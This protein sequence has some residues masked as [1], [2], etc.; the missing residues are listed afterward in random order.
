LL[1]GTLAGA[2]RAA[3]SPWYMGVGAGVSRTDI[4]A[5]LRGELDF[6]QAVL[7][8]D[9]NTS[10]WKLFAGFQLIDPL[11][12]EVSYI[13]LG[14]HEGDG[15]IGDTIAIGMDVESRVV[16]VDALARM[17]LLPALSLLARAGIY[18]W[19]SEASVL[20]DALGSR[21]FL[22]ENENGVRV[23]FGF[24]AQLDLGSLGA[25]LEWQRFDNLGGGA[26]YDLFM[27]S[28]IYSF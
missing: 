11:A 27:L 13:D 26:D 8:F 22:A 5:G 9:K 20:V 7:N 4:Q 23:N 25:R 14:A 17:S 12:V 28:G 15:K 1:G 24:G 19:S 3:D 6:S 21:D 16:S 10:G 18:H 2:V